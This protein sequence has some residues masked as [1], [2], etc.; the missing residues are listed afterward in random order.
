VADD[1]ASFISGRN[2]GYEGEIGD[3]AHTTDGAASIST[4]GRHFGMNGPLFPAAFRS[5]PR[6]GSTNREPLFE[7]A[8]H[9]VVDRVGCSMSAAW[10]ASARTSRSAPAPALIR[11]EMWSGVNLSFSAAMTSRGR[12]IGEQIPR[13]VTFVHDGLDEHRQV[14]RARWVHVGEHVP[15]GA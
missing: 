1:R 10:L 6:A 9:P 11:R 4:C 7:E 8:G 14:E 12:S 5:A 13:V 2:D 15:R 3:H